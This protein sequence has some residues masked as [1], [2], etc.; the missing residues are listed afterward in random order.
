MDAQVVA[1][2]VK[3]ELQVKEEPASQDSLPVTAG[4]TTVPEDPSGLQQQATIPAPSTAP[5]TAVLTPE[6]L[7]RCVCFRLSI[8]I[9]GSISVCECVDV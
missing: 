9:V 8:C 6:Q 3:E 7:A 2:A 5:S 1:P 4:V